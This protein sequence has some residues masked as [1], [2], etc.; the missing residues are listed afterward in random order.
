[1][2]SNLMQ[3]RTSGEGSIG[4]ARTTYEKVSP[5]QATHLLENGYY[6]PAAVIA[7]SVLDDGLR[8]LCQQNAIVLP[9]KSTIDPMNVALV[10]GG[11]YNTLLQKKITALADLRNKAAHGKWNEFDQNDVKQMIGEVRIFMENTFG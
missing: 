5:D 2:A 1:M 4:H 11:V 6:G 7:G 3:T 10:K 9:P 8:R